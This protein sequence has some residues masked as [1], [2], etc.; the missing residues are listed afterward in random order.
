MGMRKTTELG[1][2]T[3]MLGM[4]MGGFPGRKRHAERPQRE[5]V[6]GEATE[7]QKAIRGPKRGKRTKKW[8]AKQN[9]N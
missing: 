3:A 4:G 9:R 6:K 5:P 2:V 7:E 1:L 8:R